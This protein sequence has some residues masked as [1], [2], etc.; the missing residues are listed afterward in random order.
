M[1]KFKNVFM[2][3]LLVSLFAAIFPNFASASQ[4]SLLSGKTILVGSSGSNYLSTTVA[5]T[6]NNLS[7]GVSLAKG[8]EDTTIKDTLVYNFSSAQ[9]IDSVKLIITGYTNQNVSMY[10]YGTSTSTYLAAY[11]LNTLTGNNGVYDLPT[12]VTGVRQAIIYNSHTAAQTVL[13]WDLY[14]DAVPISPQLTA[15]AGDEV[16]SLNW[17]ATDARSYTVS[18]STTPG[19]PY[20]VVA[21]S[22]TSTTYTDSSVTNG[23]TYYYIVVGKN[24]EG[25]GPASNEASAT[26][27][28]DTPNAPS[29]LNAVANNEMQ[30]ITLSWNSV[31]GAT[32]YQVRRS[33]IAGGP[34]STIATNVSGTE[35]ED[36]DVEQ[37]ITYY[38]VVVALNQGVE[39]QQ[40]NEAYA[41]LEV[42]DNGRAMLTLYISGG[43]IKEYD[44][45]TAELSAFLEWYDAKDAGTGPAKYAFTKTWNKGPFKARTEYV[46]F[47]KILTFDVDE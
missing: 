4:L 10:F 44:L 39:S 24:N 40:S 37:G 20:E 17:N 42:P 12:R 15:S 14:R 28:I 29:N 5:V 9:T 35:F 46:I 33:V 32:E 34:Y 30:S 6:D 8:V 21:D 7:T 31:E 36:S 38:Y 11:N 1:N 43:Q 27:T 3:F 26:P 45:S 2:I 13:E 47:D 25:T 19:G 23:I 18:R 22:V 41:E 16:V